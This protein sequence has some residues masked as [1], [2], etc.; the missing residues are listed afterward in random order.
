MQ[1]NSVV[2]I[3]EPQDRVWL[4]GKAVCRILWLLKGPW[5]VIGWAFCL[6]FI[7]VFYRIVACHR[8]ISA[9]PI[10]LPQSDQILP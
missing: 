2:L 4:R 6:P 3:E 5:R 7:D 8:A 1:E 10:S 9:V